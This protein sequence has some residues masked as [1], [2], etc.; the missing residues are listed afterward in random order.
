MTS[1]LLIKVSTQLSG[2]TQFYKDYASRIFRTFKGSR[3]VVILFTTCPVIFCASFKSPLFLSPFSIET[4]TKSF[5]VESNSAYF[6]GSSTFRRSKFTNIPSYLRHVFFLYSLG[7]HTFNSHSKGMNFG[8]QLCN[9]VMEILLALQAF[10]ANDEIQSRK[11]DGKNGTAVDHHI[12]SVINFEKSNTNQA[13]SKSSQKQYGKYQLI[14][15][16]RVHFSFLRGLSSQ[17]SVVTQ[18]YSFLRRTLLKM[19]VSRGAKR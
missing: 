3:V 10:Y 6:A 12:V 11:H 9:R 15:R 7:R 8:C 5:K 1:S 19:Y 2:M 4:G 13:T 14:E 17:L 16:N 18:F